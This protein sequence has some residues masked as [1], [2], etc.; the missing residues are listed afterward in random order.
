VR[1]LCLVLVAGCSFVG[2]K[3]PRSALDPKTGALD[4]ASVRCSDSGVL[5]ALDA[6]GGAAAIA[7]IGGGVILEHS[8]DS[9]TYNNFSYYYAPPLLA[10]AIAFFWSASFG[11]DRIEQCE[12]LEQQARETRQIVRPITP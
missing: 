1:L 5:P 8:S 6:L 7:A 3:K 4:P 10:V 2:V 12:E 9:S 11:T